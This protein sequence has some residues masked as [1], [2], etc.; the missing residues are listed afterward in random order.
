MHVKANEI[1]DLGRTLVGYPYRHQGRTLRGGFDCAGMLIY[2]VNTLNLR[3]FDTSDY[4]RRPDPKRFD[5]FMRD[6]GCCQIGID[7]R[8]HGDVLRLAE[9]RWPV[10]CALF[11]CLCVPYIIHAWAPARKVIRERLTEIRVVQISSVWRLP[12]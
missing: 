8:E 12:E 10:H 2:I 11:D 3:D 1:V 5:G 9:T 6:A 4:S 7:D